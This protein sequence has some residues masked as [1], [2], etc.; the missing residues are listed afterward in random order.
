M[1]TARERVSPRGE[2][3]TRRVEFRLTAPELA[4]VDE[5]CRVLGVASRSQGIRLACER[6]V[7]ADRIS[8]GRERL[9]RAAEDAK[10]VLEGMAP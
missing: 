5:A 9:A 7:V 1:G 6:V 8:P 3:R 10:R 4:V 2:P